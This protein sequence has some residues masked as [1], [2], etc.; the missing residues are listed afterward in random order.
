MQ[1]TEKNNNKKQ[2]VRLKCFYWNPVS[3]NAGFHGAQPH[4]Q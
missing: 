3:K 2:V 1:D 4:K